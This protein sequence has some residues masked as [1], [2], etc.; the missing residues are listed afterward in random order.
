MPNKYLLHNDADWIDWLIAAA[1]GVGMAW[2][3]IVWW[4][5]T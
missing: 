4:F 1:C 3:L 5:L 2:F